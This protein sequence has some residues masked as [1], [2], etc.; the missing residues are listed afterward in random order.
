MLNGTV[1]ELALD[2]LE[3][4]GDICECIAFWGF[5]RIS[6]DPGATTWDVLAPLEQEVTDCL[7]QRPPDFEGVRRCTAKA[8]YLM[9]GGDES[10]S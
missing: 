6:D 8:W 2:D 9:E 4:P 3:L 10:A 1:T 7:V 5:L